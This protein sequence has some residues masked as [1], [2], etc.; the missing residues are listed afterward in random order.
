MTKVKVFVYGR[1]RQQQRRGYDNSS[2][3]FRH[4]ELKITLNV[5]IFTLRVDLNIHYL[6]AKNLPLVYFFTLRVVLH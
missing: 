2:P 3:D 4:S 5:K 1:R 6:N